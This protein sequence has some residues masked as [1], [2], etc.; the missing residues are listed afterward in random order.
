M[1]RRA[2]FLATGL[3][4]ILASAACAPRDPAS[5][6]ATQPAAQTSVHLNALADVPTTPIDTAPSK[7]L[8]QPPFHLDTNKAGVELI[9]EDETLQLKAYELGGYWFIGYGHLMLEGEPD[10][11]TEAQADEY[12]LEDIMWCERQMDKVLTSLISENEFSAL[13]SFCYNIGTGKFRKTSTVKLLNDGDR[14]GAADALLQWN[15]LN[16]VYNAHIHARR[17]KERALFLADHTPETSPVT[18]PATVGGQK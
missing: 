2:V 17:K 13:T 18:P 4:M 14:I 9:K 11:I 7:P 16:G 6:A 10:V 12:L 5:S 15:R 8:L 3:A 1:S